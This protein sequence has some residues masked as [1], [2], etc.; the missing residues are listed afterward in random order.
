[1]K[2]PPWLPDFEDP[3]VA[4]V[5]EAGIEMA[6]EANNDLHALCEQLRQPE[7][8]HSEWLLIPCLPL[9]LQ[10]VRTQVR[11]SWNRWLSPV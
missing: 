5:R 1:M 8:Q 10:P 3:I 2:K 11:W 7:R 4:E 9:P 6:R